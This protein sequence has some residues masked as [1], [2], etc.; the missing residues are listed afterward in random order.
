[1]EIRKITVGLGTTASIG[2][3][4]NIR[5]SIEL[6]A[7]LDGQD[8]PAKVM[9]E[10]WSRAVEEIH[11]QVD[12]HREANGMQPQYYDG[13]RYQ[14]AKSNLR[15]LIA[16]FPEEVRLVDELRDFNRVYQ[17]P[18]WCR[19]A[20]ARKWMEREGLATGYGTAVVEFAFQVDQLPPLPPLFVVASS[21]P[22][23]V[24]TVIPAGL[25]KELPDDFRVQREEERLEDALQIGERQAQSYRNTFVDCSDGD[26]SQLPALPERVPEPVVEDDFYDDDYDEEE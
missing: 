13:P 18:S 4:E 20:A 11:L 9:A 15:R 25:Q 12:D 6:T 19:L 7:E 26:L 8:D 17:A 3:Y 24:T 1:M 16:V 14:V 23:D 2:E 22:R 5:P 21:G 10:L